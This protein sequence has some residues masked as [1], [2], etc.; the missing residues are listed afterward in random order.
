MRRNWVKI[1]VDQ[2]LRGTMMEELEPGERWVWIG[3]LLLAGD[4]PWEDGTI[5]ITKNV[6]YTDEQL[7]DLLKVPAS[8]IKSAKK[9]MINHDKI[10]VYKSGIIRILKWH[11]YQS[12]YSRL[13]R[14]RTAKETPKSTPKSTAKDKSLDIDI[15]IDID[16]DIKPIVL[17]RELA[18]EI[19]EKWNEFAEKFQLPKVL[20][21]N[22]KSTRWGY[23]NARLKDGMNFDQLLKMIADSP[24]L[25]GQTKHAFFVTFDWI[26]LPTNYQKIIE[27][28]YLDRKA[29]GNYPGIKQWLQE[30]K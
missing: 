23:I 30:G 28:N 19:Q 10:E 13:K 7:A 21:I 4:S 16:K 18:D 12:E 22:K 6:G 20:V 29:R 15:D 14:Y 26:F 9:S 3:F 17:S 1:Y 5:S 25:I 2:C 11:Q 8:T 24:F 27:G